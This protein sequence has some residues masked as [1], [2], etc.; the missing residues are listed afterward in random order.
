MLL[1]PYLVRVLMHWLER[2][3]QAD[4]EDSRVA[5]G[6]ESVPLRTYAAK[7]Q[8]G[9]HWKGVNAGGVRPGGLPVT[10]GTVRRQWTKAGYAR[11][12]GG[13]PRC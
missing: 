9:A 6:F 11:S 2:D 3:P 5:R 8:A 10:Q 13:F 1:S 12:L 7:G 4:T